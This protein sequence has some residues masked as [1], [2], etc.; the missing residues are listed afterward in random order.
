MRKTKSTIKPV[1]E[2][3]TNNK[4]ASLQQAKKD[5][6]TATQPPFSYNKK[7]E[8][9][10]V[11]KI[12]EH[13]GIEL[14]TTQYAL[15]QGKHKIYLADASVREVL[16]MG[17]WLYECGIPIIKSTGATRSL[18]HEFSLTLGDQA[19][20]FTVELTTTQLQ[21]YCLGQE[22]ELSDEQMATIPDTTSLKYFNHYIILMYSN[23]GIGVG[24]IMGNSIKNKFFK[25]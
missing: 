23:K 6:K 19:N 25:W 4:Q 21:S 20:N 24:K 15:I 1:Q 16:T 14:D 9:D 12:K 13:Y 17:V 3:I 5:H 22:I 8:H 7:L 18:E 10:M 2:Y 11:K